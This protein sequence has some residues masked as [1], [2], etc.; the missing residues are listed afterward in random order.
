MRKILIFMTA[1]LF[2]GSATSIGSTAMTVED[3]ANDSCL[4]IVYEEIDDIDPEI[5]D[6][7]Q[8]TCIANWRMAECMGYE[9]TE[10]DYDSC[11]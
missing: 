9:V 11:L 5:F 4:D 2:L 8:L 6:D 7:E 3:M 10:A 1:L